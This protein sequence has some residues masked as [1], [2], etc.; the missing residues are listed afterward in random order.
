M[1]YAD[2]ERFE[3]VRFNASRPVPDRCEGCTFVDCDFTEANLSR[4]RFT[5]CAFVGCDLSNCGMTGAGFQGV[6]LERCKALGVLW[7]TC[8]QLLFSVRMSECVLDLGSWNGCDLSRSAYFGGSLRECDFTGAQCE[9]TEF[10][11]VNLT[12]ARFEDTAL[13]GA[14][15]SGVTGLELDPALNRVQG[16]RVDREALPGLLFRWGLEIE[17][18]ALN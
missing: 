18:D 15:F 16:M 11:G 14:R 17:G 12:G 13:K 1:E 2:D 7:E 6:T 4:R 3:G 8:E 5:D 9:G 10:V